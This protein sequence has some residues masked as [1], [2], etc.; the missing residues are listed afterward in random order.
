V[1]TKRSLWKDED[2]EHP[3]EFGEEVQNELRHFRIHNP[4]TLHVS[5]RRM[6]RVLSRSV[7]SRKSVSS[8]LEKSKAVHK[9]RIG[10]EALA[11]ELN[12]VIWGMNY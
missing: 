3:R 7:I 5:E 6:R 10:I 4:T 12:P 11:C 1:Q 9:R 2:R 8:L